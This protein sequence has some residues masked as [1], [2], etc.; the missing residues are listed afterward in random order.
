[1]TITTL[2][3][4]ELNQDVTKA[5][6]ATKDGPV[7]IT[8]RGRPAHV[9]LSFEEYQRLTRERRNIADSLAMP[10]VEDIE[11]DPPRANVKIKEVNF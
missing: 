8:D 3:S 11:F 9:L 4:R 2:S 7:F 6:K 10:G 1:M 5:K